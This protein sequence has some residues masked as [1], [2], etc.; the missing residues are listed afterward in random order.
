MG[1]EMLCIFNSF[2]YGCPGLELG[3]ALSW[4]CVW[5]LF[6]QSGWQGVIKN[7]LAFRGVRWELPVHIHV[8]L[9]H[10]CVGG[11]SNLHPEL[12]FPALSNRRC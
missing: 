9:V 7:L 2:A 11:L 5:H 6:L 12:A 4:T 1:N 3:I 8:R 10:A